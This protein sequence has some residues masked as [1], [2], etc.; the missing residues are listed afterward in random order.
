MDTNTK[1]IL[2]MAILGLPGLLAAYYAFRSS[3]KSDAI[4]TNVQKIETQTNSNTEMLAK[5]SRIAGHGEGKEE[6]RAEELAAKALRAQGAAAITGII[7]APPPT[8]DFPLAAPGSAIAEIEESLGK[9]Q[10]ALK[11]ATEQK[12]SPAQIAS[13]EALVKDLSQLL[14]KITRVT[15]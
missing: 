15:P 12:L 14:G 11:V 2:Q 6:A 9:V 13:M 3:K 4:A 1:D 7:V 10:G 8:P 5:A